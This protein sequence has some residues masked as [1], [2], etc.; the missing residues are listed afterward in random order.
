MV[1]LLG[2]RSSNTENLLRTLCEFKSVIF[3]RASFL[4]LKMMLRTNS[5]ESLRMMGQEGL[6]FLAGS[7]KTFAMIRY[8]GKAE[9]WSE[10]S[11]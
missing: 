5:D 11:P 6:S 3:G 1:W 8:G 7:E 4:C 2:E 9:S 10:M